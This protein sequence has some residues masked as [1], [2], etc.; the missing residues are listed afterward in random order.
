MERFLTLK[1]SQDNP[2]LQIIFQSL[3]I[4]LGCTRNIFSKEI[5]FNH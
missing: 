4:K 3:E 2:E 5:T 1:I